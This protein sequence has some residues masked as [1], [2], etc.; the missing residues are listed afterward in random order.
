[1]PHIGVFYAAKLGIWFFSFKWIHGLQILSMNCP[2]TVK[3]SSIRSVVPPS[4]NSAISAL[5]FSWNQKLPTAHSS[6][7]LPSLKSQNR[8][9]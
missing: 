1:M 6:S 2:V 4:I 9:F 3:C 8:H 5:H 7:A